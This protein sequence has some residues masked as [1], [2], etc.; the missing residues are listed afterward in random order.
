MTRLAPAVALALLPL[1]AWA[2]DEVEPISPDR[3]GASTSTDT[4]GRGAVHSRRGWPTRVSERAG[5]RRSGASTSTWRSA[6]E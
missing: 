6:S 3:A 4:V 2:Q 1:G 5:R